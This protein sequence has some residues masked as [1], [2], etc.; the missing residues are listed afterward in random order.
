MKYFGVKYE[1]LDSHDNYSTQRRKMGDDNIR[2]KWE[3]DD[4]YEPGDVEEPITVS[5]EGHMDMKAVELVM[6]KQKGDKSINRDHQM[7]LAESTMR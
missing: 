4:E 1:C 2:F 7:R 6:L 5:V 3:G